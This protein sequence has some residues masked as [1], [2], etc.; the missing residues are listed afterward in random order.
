[1][2][3]LRTCCL[4][5]GDALASCVLAA[6]CFVDG[7]ECASFAMQMLLC[8]SAAVDLRCVLPSCWRCA[9]LMLTCFLPFHAQPSTSGSPLSFGLPNP[10]AFPRPSPHPL[11][12]PRHTTSPSPRPAR[13]QLLNAYSRGSKGELATTTAAANAEAA[14][15]QTG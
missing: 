13:A 11:P 3:V 14:S 12:H 6:G 7:N 9:M 10:H 4:C 15:Q 1:M 8:G 2:C 5:S